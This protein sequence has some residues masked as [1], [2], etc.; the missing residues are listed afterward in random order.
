MAYP[1]ES[2]GGLGPVLAD[3][4]REAGIATTDEFL[5]R[6]GEAAGRGAL[7]AATGI[8]EGALLRWARRCDL[9]RVHG[10][11][12]PMADLLEAAGI[13][14][15]AGLAAAAPE[16]LAL[17]LAA[18]NQDGAFCPVTPGERMVRDWIARAAGLRL[19]L[20]DR[21]ETTRRADAPRT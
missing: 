9:F 15:V 1:I 6:A 13:A 18:L 21:G 20:D 7:A 10:V 4:L 2:V 19:V 17:R 16:P 8:D 14:T 5:A 11:G 12:R 3:R